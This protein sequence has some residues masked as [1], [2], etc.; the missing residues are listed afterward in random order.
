M[1]SPKKK[2]FLRTLEIPG[3]RRS[4]P[5]EQPTPEPVKVKPAPEAKPKS[6]PVPEA[7]PKPKPVKKE[8][9]VK[10][11]NKA[12]VSSVVKPKKKD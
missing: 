10:A 12:K 5:L 7:K 6:K 3:V 11:P 4:V 9:K 2:R 1:A 8:K